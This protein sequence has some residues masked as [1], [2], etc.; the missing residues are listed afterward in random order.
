MREED[1]TQGNSKKIFNKSSRL[2]ARMYAFSNRVI[3]T[4]DNLQE[5]LVNADKVEMF[6]SRLSKV[7]RDQKQKL[8]YRANS[9]STTRTLVCISSFL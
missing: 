9:I 1:V 2:N 6:Q 5:W 8:N 3:S 4:L 7:W